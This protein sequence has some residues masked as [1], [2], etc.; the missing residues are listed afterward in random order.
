MMRGLFCDTRAMAARCLLLSKRNPDIILTSV[1][2]P[3]LMMILFTYVLGG[4]MDVGNG[5]YVNFIVPGILLQSLGQCAATTAISV[6]TDIKTGIIDR[7]CTM[8]IHK[9]SVL[10]GHVLEAFARNVLA[11]VLVIAVALLVGFRPGAGLT[12]WLVTACILVL[13]ILAMSW[14]SV[15]FGILAKSPEGAGAFSVFAIA[16]PYLSSGFVPIDTMPEALRIFAKY[17]PMTPIIDTLRAAL[18]G[19]AVK[20]DTCVVAMSWCVVLLVVFYL[21]SVKIFKK[22]TSN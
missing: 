14:I 18:T 10:T 16:L 5:S 3:V 20:I 22:R 12:G 6:S 2:T 11:S 9:S 7:F 21:L 13:Y 8:P 17:Q 19:S 1:V 4:A 15:F